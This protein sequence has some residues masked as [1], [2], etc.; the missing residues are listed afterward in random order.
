MGSNSKVQLIMAG[1]SEQQELEA[2]GHDHI[3]TQEAE[4]DESE[5]EFSSLSLFSL[6]PKESCH[7]QSGCN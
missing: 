5:L 3:L 1:K 4:S 7:P 6:L 2:T